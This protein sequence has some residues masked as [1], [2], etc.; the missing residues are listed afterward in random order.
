MPMLARTEGSE[1][2]KR[3]SVMVSTEVGN[4]RLVIGVLLHCNSG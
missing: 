3:T 1:A 4:V 2:L